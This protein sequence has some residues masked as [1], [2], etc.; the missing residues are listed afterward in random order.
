MKKSMRKVGFAL[1]CVSFSISGAC[2]LTEAE[3]LGERCLGTSG[4]PD[5]VQMGAESV[6]SAGDGCFATTFETGVCP[7]EHGKCYRDSGSR[8]YCMKACPRGQVACDGAC[9]DPQ[10]STAYCGAEDTCE[11]AGCC[12]G[13]TVCSAIEACVGGKCQQTACEGVSTRCVDGVVYGCS[14]GAWKVLQMCVYGCSEDETGCEGERPCQYQGSVLAHGV[15]ACSADRK[16]VLEC[17]DGAMVQAQ[18]CVS[19]TACESGECVTPVYMGC[20]WN[21]TE[22]PHN[23]AVCEGNSVRTCYDGFL[24]M[25]GCTQDGLTECRDGMCQAPLLC[26]NMGV[27]YASGETWCRD[28]D[29]L[30]EC[31]EGNIV[32]VSCGPDGVCD[33]D[34]VAA[35]VPSYRSIRSLRRDYEVLISKASCGTTD[36]L[37]VR[38]DVVVEGVVTALRSNAGF[39]MQALSGE[40]AYSGLVVFCK[41]GS[42]LKYAD[43]TSVQVGDRVRVTAD[44]VNGYYCQMQIQALDK[45]LVIE[46]TGTGTVE[47]V[48]LSGVEI[49]DPGTEFEADHPYNGVLVNVPVVT[50]DEARTTNPKGWGVT[51]ADGTPFLVSD[52]FRTS[53]LELDKNYSV[54]GI[55]VW[56]FGQPGLAVRQGMASDVVEVPDCGVGETSS[57]CLKRHGVD[58]V[59][60]CRDG[61]RDVA[62][63]VN[64]TTRDQVCSMHRDGSSSEE[65]PY[66]RDRV[67]CLSAGGNEVAEGK[68]GCSDASTLSECTFHE[69]HGETTCAPSEW[70][71]KA[72]CGA[73]KCNE[74]LSRCDAPDVEKCEFTS[75]DSAGATVR[76]VETELLGADTLSASVYCTTDPTAPVGAWPYVVRLNWNAECEDCGASVI[77]YVSGQGKLPSADGMYT[78]VSVVSVDGGGSFVCPRTMNAPTV[79][80]NQTA[81]ATQTREMVL[82]RV[83]ENLAVWT[84]QDQNLAADGGILSAGALLSVE[85]TTASV[86]YPGNESDLAVACKTEWSTDVS[87]N[88]AKDPHWL[89]E[90]AATGYEEITVQFR[91]RANNSTPGR[92]ALAYGVG[93]GDWVSVG[94][95]VAIPTDN[96]W[97]NY[98]ETALPKAGNQS[99]VRIGFYPYQTQGAPNIRLDDIVIRGK[100]MSD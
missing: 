94:T 19:G 52:L 47:P 53:N 9:V 48:V 71:M 39:V 80:G 61:V 85:G 4:H 17:S 13:Y 36:A 3:D 43:K 38:A 41:A 98:P 63:D 18:N 15:Y 84:F 97:V 60:T 91:T 69:C 58:F 26:R 92:M 66:C 70:T 73:G 44:G 81:A 27:T 89:L 29:I 75:L 37:T 74:A 62:Q 30:V 23:G 68:L 10:T 12:L 11:G 50:A 90:M 40:A 1:I 16:R 31:R 72:R 83:M 51:D 99:R 65:V 20:E 49:D 8:Y 82:G 6:C 93:S 25:L 46:K 87:P 42:C 57:K 5:Y 95:D 32:E 7:Y 76:V 14:D 2:T 78:C 100:K 96:T 33:S 28:A 86:S 55:V 64:C 35:C 67:T 77:E 56:T 34:P 54:T 45:A 21:G 59:V 22:V 24:D 88:L 79:L